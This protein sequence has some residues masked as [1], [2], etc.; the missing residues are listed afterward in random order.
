MGRND[1]SFPF[2]H[3]CDE[4]GSINRARTLHVPQLALT[5]TEFP[6]TV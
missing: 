3:V 5:Q 2:V 6:A 4:R 1:R